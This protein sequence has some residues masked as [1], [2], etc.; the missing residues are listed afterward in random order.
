MEALEGG[1]VSYERDTPVD[2]LCKDTDDRV[3]ATRVFNQGHRLFFHFLAA[4]FA[5]QML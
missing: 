5:T 2:A 3:D 4:D 1:A